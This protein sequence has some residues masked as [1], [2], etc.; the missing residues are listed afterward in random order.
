MNELKK[1]IIAIG[2]IFAWC[3]LIA[4]GFS[5]SSSYA[6]PQQIVSLVEQKQGNNGSSNLQLQEISSQSHQNIQTGE[7]AEYTFLP[8]SVEKKMKPNWD[9][10]PLDELDKYLLDGH[11]WA[12]FALIN[13]KCPIT[14]GSG[15][16]DPPAVWETW[17]NDV[18]TFPNN[19]DT[20]KWPGECTLRQKELRS[21]SKV[22]RPRRRLGLVK[23]E[24]GIE[25]D[26]CKDAICEEVRRNKASFEYIVEKQLW[27]QNGR[28]Q[29]FQNALQTKPPKQPDQFIDFPVNTIEIKADWCKVN[30]DDPCKLEEGKK[31]GYQYYEVEVNNQSYALV[32]MHI[33]TKE[34]P[35]WFWATWEWG[36]NPSRCDY[37]GCHDSFGLTKE[38]R[39]IQPNTLVAQGYAKEELSEDLKNLFKKYNLQ[40]VFQSY[41]LK[42]TQISFV[43]E[44][45]EPTL[46]GNSI[47]EE[48]FVGSSSC[49]TCHARAT[50]NSDGQAGLSIFKFPFPQPRELESYNGSPNPSWYADESSEN[51]KNL[52]ADFVWALT[53]P[54]KPKTPYL[55]AN[56]QQ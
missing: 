32:G 15:A 38:H 30:K 37:I 5:V 44:I 26:K 34:F 27:N 36:G 16:A 56:S 41:R 24:V 19:G 14:N 9:K 45:G 10:D 49:I 3:L 53:S 54:D 20:P 55:K 39:D 11:A 31:K 35:N 22:E 29:A 42:G 47:I 50:I 28:K 46:L 6:S 7:L 48:G 43:N 33:M 17:A 1:K 2:C 23:S 12:L 8:D 21:R 4:F 52:P 13:Q 18:E 51:F 25:V 40:D